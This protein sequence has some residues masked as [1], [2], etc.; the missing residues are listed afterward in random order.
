MK[1]SY[2]RKEWTALIEH[3]LKIEG[4][5]QLARQVAFS[6]MD[7]YFQSGRYE[8]E[9]I[10]LLCEMATFS[11]MLEVNRSGSAA[12]FGIIVEGLC[13]DFEEM[14][15]YTYNRVMSQVIS[16]CRRLPAGKDL[17]GRLNTFG[18]RS[19]KDFLERMDKIR[20]DDKLL[21]SPKN[22][23]KILLLSRVT[24]GA[25]VAITSVVVQRL[26]SMFPCAEIVILG[27]RKLE[28]IYGGN[29]R[30]R[31]RE[32]SYGRC[33][34]LI[35][36]LSRWHDVLENIDRE[37]GSCPLEECILIDPDSRLSQLGILPL[38]PLQYYFFFDSRSA[39]SFNN[40]MSVSELTNR[41]LDSIMVTTQ[42]CYPAVW[43]SQHYLDKTER[44][45]TGLRNK[46][47]SAIIIINFG[48][49]GYHR[50]RVE[51]DFEKDLLL[52]LIKEPGTV[53]ILD[54]G[55]GEEESDQTK[56]LMDS[57]T[58]HGHIVIHASF[59]T[60]EDVQISSGIIGIHCSIGEI[61]ALI[62]NGDEFIGYDSACQHIAAALGVKTLTIFAGSNNM[63]FVRRWSACGKNKPT[64]VHVDTLS[65]HSYGNSTDLVRRV[66]DA[67]INCNRI[68]PPTICSS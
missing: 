8:E 50:K 5:S 18:V 17:D 21:P 9:Y 57:M 66:M 10:D 25:D 31:I 44:F 4:V 15:T 43:P 63:R 68:A 19:T 60:L 38:I 65:T 14:Q 40:M 3:G 36:R 7:H 1:P 42:S 11:D 62:A 28:E 67:R 41:W 53:I 61:A 49:G 22:I 51:G 2:Y 54:R 56:A 39:G 59:D 37:I 13:D 58:G 23:R 32:V 64:I 16:F 26:S 46:G 24:I 20:A 12:L 6:F 27:S 55:F 52:E 45:C 47:A 35:E 34:G 29:P 48:V 33:G 30:I